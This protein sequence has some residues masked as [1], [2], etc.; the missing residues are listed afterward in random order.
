MRETTT[1]ESIFAETET[2]WTFD[3]AVKDPAVEEP[4][5]YFWH[6]KVAFQL[7]R[8]LQWGFAWVTPARLTIFSG[9]L[10]ALAGWAYYRASADGPVWFF[11]GSALLFISVVFDC[12]DGMLARLRGGGTPFGMLLDGAMDLVVGLCVWFGLAHSA[13]A[14]MTQWWAWPL[15]F[16]ALVSIVVHCALYDSVKNFFVRHSLPIAARPPVKPTVPTTPI[17]KATYLLYS[18]A[19]GLVARVFGAGEDEA[20][21]AADPV[22][23]RREFSGTMRIVGWL[24]LGTHLVV[25]YLAA[26]LGA[27]ARPAPFIAVLVVVGIGLNGLMFVAVAARK[28]AAQRLRDRLNA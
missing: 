23:F 22:E 26:L 13:L 16:F 1:V 17:A 7:M 9:I 14:G 18:T 19:Y 10:G 15:A 8:P 21:E 27:F 24:G 4:A 6:R 20:L 3:A 28:R 12:M 2:P 5:D 25:V 11:I